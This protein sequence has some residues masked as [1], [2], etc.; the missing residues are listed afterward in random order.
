MAPA[1]TGSNTQLD[2]A[3]TATQSWLT[4]V[5]EEKYA[6]SWNVAAKVFQGALS[7]ESWASSVAGARG[8]LGKLVSRQFK[9]AEFKNSLP[10]APDGK[11]VVVQ[12]TTSF[13]NKAT[14][15]ETVTPMQE[16]DGTWKVSGYFIK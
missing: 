15:V 12:F 8:P 11:Y 5:N 7:R 3:T 6:E 1:K 13:E 2:A 9:S 16:G 14:A 10:G 4:L